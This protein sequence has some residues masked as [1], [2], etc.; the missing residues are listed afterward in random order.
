[1]LNVMPPHTLGHP[2][3]AHASTTL[4]L[5]P[6]QCD[7]HILIY[8]GTPKWPNSSHEIGNNAIVPNLSSSS[9]QYINE[10]TLSP[11][12]ALSDDLPMPPPSTN[13]C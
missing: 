10:I 4:L 3:C 1:M 9:T 6:P 8:T 2:I 7:L 13:A 12:D 5:H 11:Y